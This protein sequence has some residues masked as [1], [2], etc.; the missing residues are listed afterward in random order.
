MKNSL[1][2]QNDR[3]IYQLI[4]AFDNQRDRDILPRKYAKMRKNA[5]AF[6]RGTCHLFYRDLPVDSILNLAPVTW[7]CGDLHLENFGA[8]KGDDR[9]IYFGINDFDEGV[10]APCAW[11]IARL[12]TSIFL[13]VDSLLFTQSDAHTLAQIYLNSYTK[14]LNAGRIREIVEDNARGMVADLLEDLHRRKRSAFLDERT[15]LVDEHR[16]LKF[17]GEK[18]MEISKDRD[19]Q[20]RQAISNW[21]KTQVN[22][23][24]F[25]VLDVGFRVAGTGSLGLDRYLILVAGKGSPDRN[26]LLDFKQQSISSLQ[27]YLTIVQPEW[28]NQA[29]RVMRVQSLVR[30]APPALLAA[31]EFNGGSYL[32]RELQPTQDKIE[33]KPGKIS[34][35][36]LAQLIDTMGE[37]TAFAHLHGSGKSGAAIAQA[38]IDFGGNVDWQ[39]EVIIYANNYA[40]QVQIDYQYFCQ[41][42]QDL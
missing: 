37:V 5:F 27:P 26:Y 21:A 18:I 6:F 14:A 12:L 7:I 9:Q 38:L 31:I 13:A 42:T 20:V 28:E 17:D 25:D 15:E 1:F 23:D 10:L 40:S 4:Q 39:Q 34:L 16:Q 19:R 30:S 36:E 29:T 2:N 8:Y 3:D 35:A 22:P 11:D 24:F 33:L 32:L 41:A